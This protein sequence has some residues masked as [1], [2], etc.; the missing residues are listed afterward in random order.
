MS[1]GR[2]G[3]SR[4]AQ[5]M[6]NGTAVPMTVV[7]DHRD[8]GEHRVSVQSPWGPIIPRVELACASGPQDYFPKI[9]ARVLVSRLGADWYVVTGVFFDR[10]TNLSEEPGDGG[11]KNSEK[12]DETGSNERQWVWKGMRLVM[13]LDPNTGRRTVSILGADD[14]KIQAKPG[15]TVRLSDGTA[16]DNVPLWNPLK[17]LLTDIVARQN[18]NTAQLQRLTQGVPDTLRTAAAA[19]AISNPPL[20]AILTQ[21]A[22]EMDAWTLETAENTPEPTDNIASGLVRISS[23]PMR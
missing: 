9:G 5:K 16:E 11:G 12:P 19:V 23:T 20:A 21:R 22:T 14:V 15:G 7:A 17:D 10:D 3:E 1:S 4:F 6:N 8:D 13:T 18:A 2:P